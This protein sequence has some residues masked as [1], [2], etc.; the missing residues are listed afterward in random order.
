MLK[1]TGLRL[2]N[3]VGV[4]LTLLVFAESL[5]MA[6]PRVIRAADDAAYPPQIML[7]KD[8]K[9]DGLE[10]DLMRA[11]E[12]ETGLQVEWQLGSW[13]DAV[14]KLRNRQVEIIPGMNVTAERKR[15]FLFT[16]PYFE[17]RVVLFVAQDSYHI[18]GLEDLRDRRVG[19]QKGEVAG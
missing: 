4:A 2:L 18:I 14:R 19:I 15:E 11:L 7:R 17:D 10:A 6:A 1:Q 3:F 9:A 12:R 5:V 8:G 16:R 13:D